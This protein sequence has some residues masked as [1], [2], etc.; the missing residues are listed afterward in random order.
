MR[1]VMK[2]IGILTFFRDENP[3]TFLQ[4]YSSQKAFEREML[5]GDKPK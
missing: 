4:A 1:S 3:G 2:K 5:Q